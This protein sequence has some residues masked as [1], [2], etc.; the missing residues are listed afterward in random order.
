M[1]AFQ[2]LIAADHLEEHGDRET[3]ALLR[4][5]GDFLGKV[6]PGFEFPPGGWFVHGMSIEIPSDD[7]LQSFVPGPPEMRFTVSFFP[8]VDQLISPRAADEEAG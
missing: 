1:N 4:T 3:A 5:F 7:S 2:L 8:A 6:G